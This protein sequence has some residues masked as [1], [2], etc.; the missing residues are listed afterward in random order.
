MSKISSIIKM[1]SLLCVLMFLSGLTGQGEKTFAQPLNAGTAAAQANPQLTALRLKEKRLLAE[2][3][4]INGADP[5]YAAMSAS[6]QNELTTLQKDIQK[7]ELDAAVMPAAGTENAIGAAG[8]NPMVPD[9]AEME[10]TQ[11]LPPQNL[12]QN[13]PPNNLPGNKL[14]DNIEMPPAGLGGSLIPPPRPGFDNKAFYQ[15]LREDITSQLRQIQDMLRTLQPQDEQLSKMLKG[16]QAELMSQLQEL[17]KQMGAAGTAKNTAKTD[18][19]TASATTPTADATGLTPSIPPAAAIP[20]AALSPVSPAAPV[21][22]SVEL[23]VSGASL[24]NAEQ[25][26]KIEQAAK[27]LREAGLEQMAVQVSMMGNLPLPEG[28]AAA[29]FSWNGEN[30]SLNSRARDPFAAEPSQE[31]VE[32]KKSVEELK[33]DLQKVSTELE[34]ITSQLKLISHKIVAESAA[35]PAPVTPAPAASAPAAEKPK[36]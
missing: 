25:S 35:A 30:N 7:L 22:P 26:K 3:R 36:K 19:A 24:P 14:P 31:V 17:D 2:L 32:L 5:D 10:K 9:P 29:P 13:L 33:S 20:P 21:T 12:P 15:Q 18:P 1:S 28:G 34:N 8:I 23:P 4:N 27:L 16:Q 6:I 11:N